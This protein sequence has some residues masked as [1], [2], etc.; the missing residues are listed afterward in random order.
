MEVNPG[1]RGPH[2]R[3][4]EMQTSDKTLLRREKFKIDAMRATGSGGD[5]GRQARRRRLRRRLRPDLRPQDG[6][7]RALADGLGHV[8]LAVTRHGNDGQGQPF[9]N[10]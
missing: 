8:A 2:S 9:G 1:E 4:W 10:W 7:R 6:R 3:E 5:A